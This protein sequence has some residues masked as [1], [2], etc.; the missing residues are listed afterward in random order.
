MYVNFSSMNSIN[1]LHRFEPKLRYVFL[2]CYT[3][4]NCLFICDTLWILIMLLSSRWGRLNTVKT[5]PL[6]ACGRFLLLKCDSFTPLRH[7]CWRK[8]RRNPKDPCFIWVHK[9]TMMRLCVA[10]V[11]F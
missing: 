7:I 10:A 3:M 1:D 11:E 5:H 6:P 2:M 4:V 9:T 8:S